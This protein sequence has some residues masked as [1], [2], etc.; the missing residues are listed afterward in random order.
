MVRVPNRRQTTPLGCA[1]A[2]L[3][4]SRACITSWLGHPLGEAQTFRCDR[5]DAEGIA[6]IKADEEDA[7][8]SSR[9]QQLGLQL[10]RQPT[11]D[12]TAVCQQS[13][14]SAAL[15]SSCFIAFR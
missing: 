4:R 2:G 12:E 6:V 14:Y 15:P 8:Q 11:N 7:L 10:T 9:Q 3:A 5:A 13:G 1:V